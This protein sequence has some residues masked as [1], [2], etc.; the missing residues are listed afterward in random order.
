M[1]PRPSHWFILGLI[2]TAFS[3]FAADSSTDSIATTP[4]DAA[5]AANVS[6][7]TA[8][9]V[10]MVHSGV[11]DGVVMAYIN[12]ATS[13]FGLTPDNII[14]LHEAGLTSTEIVAMIRQDRLIREGALASADGT[15]PSAPPAAT[16]QPPPPEQPSETPEY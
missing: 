10:K 7:A 12:K 9:I 13:P 15:I 16:D 2:L 1:K 6:P 3:G 11:S 5:S 14:Y 4:D 8:E